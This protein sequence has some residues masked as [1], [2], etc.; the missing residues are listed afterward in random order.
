[1]QRMHNA[2]QCVRA[3]KASL[4]RCIKM[5]EGSVR[6]SP[7]KTSGIHQASS[8][9]AV[10][11]SALCISQAAALHPLIHVEHIASCLS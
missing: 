10:V 6:P 5:V 1:M 2:D 9:K 8:W 4:V 7:P 11:W 3:G